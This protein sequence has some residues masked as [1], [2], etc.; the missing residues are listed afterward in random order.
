M[1]P[2][3]T[4]GLILA[5]NAILLL[6]VVDFCPLKLIYTPEVHVYFHNLLLRLEFLSITVGHGLK[7]V[8][9]KIGH[10]AE[11]SL[12]MNERRCCGGHFLWDTLENEGDITSD[13]GEREYFG[14]LRLLVS[15]PISLCS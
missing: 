1:L 10:S 3:P 11:G 13:R 7:T 15:L 9:E 4:L 6:R 5:H 8:S 14:R 12:G 2:S